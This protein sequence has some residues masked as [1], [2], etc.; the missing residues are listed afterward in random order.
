MLRTMAWTCPALSLVLLIVTALFRR[1]GEPKYPLPRKVIARGILQ[2]AVLEL[3]PPAFKV[4]L[5][6][7][8]SVP[9]QTTAPKEVV[10]SS[11]DKISDARRAFAAAINPQKAAS[12]EFRVW[13]IASDSSTDQ[14]LF[15]AD[16]LR[17][18]GASLFEDDE[19]TVG[20]ELVD[21]S[22]VFV[23]E[24][25]NRDKWIVDSAQV[26]SPSNGA[27]TVPPPPSTQP[28]PLFNS[29]PDFFTQLQQRT[30][31]TVGT[32]AVTTFKPSPVSA[33]KA[34]AS[35]SRLKAQHDPGTLG[36]SNM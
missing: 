24:F 19:R 14:L 22:E 11:T 36:L 29:G 6:A 16:D 25:K 26:A 31:P 4:H 23:V 18:R 5:L 34:G 3:R 17:S 21:S 2:E 35:G 12:G 32:T 33:N 7:P 13:K 15:T 28:G 9:G 8:S 10:V 1:Y 30:A 27:S 20:D